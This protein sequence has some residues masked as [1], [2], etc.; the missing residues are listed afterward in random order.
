M[1]GNYMPATFAP[2]V[3]FTRFVITEKNTFTNATNTFIST[4][5]VPGPVV[6][7][8]LPG[9]VAACGGLLALWRRKRTAP[10]GEA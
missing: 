10:G 1:S 6:G 4:S 2:T 7:A 5:V 9:L 8:G 3:V